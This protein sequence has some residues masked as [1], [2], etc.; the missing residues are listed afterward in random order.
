[1]WG[2]GERCGEEVGDMGKRWEVWGRGERCGKR[3]EVWGRG[4]RCGEEVGGV[5]GCVNVENPVCT[6]EMVSLLSHLNVANHWD[7]SPCKSHPN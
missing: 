5:V 3:W 1:M 2:R 7:V 4:G 6:Y